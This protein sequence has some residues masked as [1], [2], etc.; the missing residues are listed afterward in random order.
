LRSLVEDGV[1]RHDLVGRELTRNAADA[2]GDAFAA[3]LT[4]AL[5]RDRECAAVQ[6]SRE[7][8]EQAVEGR[9]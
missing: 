6:P 2:D 5:A 3:E 1:A 9:Q 7:D 8:V 4:A